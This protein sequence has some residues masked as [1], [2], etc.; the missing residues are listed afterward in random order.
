MHFCYLIIFAYNTFLNV[1]IINYDIFCISFSVF[2]KSFKEFYK[3]FRE[4]PLVDLVLKYIFMVL[5]R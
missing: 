1:I 2:L 4:Y 5:V 3:D